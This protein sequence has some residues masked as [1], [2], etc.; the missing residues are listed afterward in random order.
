MK[1]QLTEIYRWGPLSF[2]DSG[3]GGT[4][5]T[6]QKDSS[7]FDHQLPMDG[8]QDRLGGGVPQKQETDAD[9]S[10]K[11]FLVM[12]GDKHKR[13]GAAPGLI[14]SFATAQTLWQREKATGRSIAMDKWKNALEPIAD[15][16]DHS[17]TQRGLITNPQEIL[18]NKVERRDFV[19]QI[20]EHDKMHA[21]ARDR[22]GRIGQMAKIGGCWD[23]NKKK[24]RRQLKNF[25]GQEEAKRYQQ[26]RPE[27]SQQTRAQLFVDAARLLLKFDQNYSEAEPPLIRVGF[28]TRQALQNV[29]RAQQHPEFRVRPGDY[30]TLGATLNKVMQWTDGNINQSLP[31]EA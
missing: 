3:G 22:L 15:R 29:V 23:S 1:R 28:D 9:G 11:S 13:D 2:L 27:E 18:S 5:P 25:V 30:N 8:G 24:W 14:S 19:G 4:G 10:L 20:V 17:A 7:V 16:V 26:M 21:V 6:W 12:T 31:F